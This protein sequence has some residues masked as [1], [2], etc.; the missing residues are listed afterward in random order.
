[1]TTKNNI[2]YFLGH[3]HLKHIYPCEYFRRKYGKA[4]DSIKQLLKRR[5]RLPYPE[6]V[7]ILPM[8]V[9]LSAQLNGSRKTVEETDEIE[10]QII[11]A[12]IYTLTHIVEQTEEQTEEHKDYDDQ[13]SSYYE[14]EYVY[15][16]FGQLEN[17]EAIFAKLDNSLMVGKER[18]PIG[19]IRGT[20][21]LGKYLA[22]PI[23]R[24]FIDCEQ[25]LIYPYNNDKK[26]VVTYHP[27]FYLN[28]PKHPFVQFEYAE[29]SYK[30]WNET[31]QKWTRSKFTQALSSE[32]LADYDGKY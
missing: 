9:G 23:T 12:T 26:P 21:H 11:T 17:Q 18:L 25:R 5:R 27:V 31:T 32:L 7:K 10:E 1:M 22:Y 19:F 8:W 16:V 4:R 30:L 2:N 6:E 28:E 13:Y 3:R 14:Y 24:D 20:I 29:K 15:L